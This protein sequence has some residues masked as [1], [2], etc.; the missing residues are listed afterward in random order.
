MAESDH[1][2]LITLV[3]R[4]AGIDRRVEDG[5]KQVKADVVTARESYPTTEDIAKT[6]TAESNRAY[7]RAAN[8]ARGM[9]ARVEQAVR[10]LE[11]RVDLAAKNAGDK[12]DRIELT[13][14][15]A[16]EDMKSRQ[17]V[18]SAAGAVGAILGTAGIIF[19]LVTG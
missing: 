2:L 9:V 4:V 1:D 6:A 18:V 12:Q 16:I 14:K 17:T 8:E 19:G 15:N 10:G 13:F 5:F 7:E 3:E 11:E